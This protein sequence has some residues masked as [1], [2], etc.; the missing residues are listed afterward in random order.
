MDMYQRPLIALALVALCL[1]LAACGGSSHSVSTSATSASAV[2]PACYVPPTDPCAGGG[3]PVTVSYTATVP[4]TFGDWE[5]TLSV[6]KFDPALGTRSAV[7]YSLAGTAG[8]AAA[9][10]NLDPNAGETVDAS[11]SEVMTLQRPDLSALLTLT[12]AQTLPAADLAVFDGNDDWAGDDAITWAVS[13]S[14]TVSGAAPSPASDLAFFTS[15]GAS[16]L[17]LVFPVAAVG[18]SG[19]N[20]NGND[21]ANFEVSSG[22]VLTVTYTYTPP[23]TP[24]TPTPKPKPPCTGGWNWGGGSHSGS[25]CGTIR[26]HKSSTPVRYV[27]RDNSWCR[28]RTTSRWGR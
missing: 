28:S 11:I 15:T 25:G 16:D 13:A 23:C 1:S 18:A 21:Q 22:A 2:K 9:V 20:G 24:T 8:G 14:Q 6:P 10:E 27:H 5:T 17:N 12:A 26:K 4:Q 19:Y 3:T 7:S